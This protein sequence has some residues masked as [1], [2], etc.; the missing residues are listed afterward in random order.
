V[1]Q[2]PLIEV[3]VSSVADAIAAVAAG[4]D[5]IELC[6]A[7]ELGGLT[8]SAALIESVVEQVSVPVMAMIRPRPGGFHYSPDEFRTCLLDAEWAL[9][10]GAQGI[11][12][13][14]LYDDGSIDETRSR[15]M[16][17]V[18]RDRE[19]VFHR[20]FDY[21]VTPLASAD[22]LVSMGVTRL[23]T[24]GQSPTALTGAYL[25]R[26]IADR[27]RGMLQVMPGGGIR[28]DNI[29]GVL[30]QT[31]CHQV[32]LG[33]GSFAEDRSLDGN[34]DLQLASKLRSPASYRKLDV[35]LLAAATEK[36]R[37]FRVTQPTASAPNPAPLSGNQN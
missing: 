11:V 1:T 20:A 37:R 19:T 27:T 16:V 8:P 21:A 6:T 10:L 33:A 34:S 24:S 3:C 25:I 36:V 5:R 4:A 30:G 7:L 17:S 32:H 12:F 28:P 23:L 2:R 29:C 22:L 31:G 15:E 14:C 9:S 35:E 26:E 13:G 18:A